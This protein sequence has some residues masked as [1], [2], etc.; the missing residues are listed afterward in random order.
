M[1]AL[2]IVARILDIVNSTIADPNT[3]PGDGGG[4][5]RLVNGEGRGG[6]SLECWRAAADLGFL[7]DN[8]HLK[9]RLVTGC[10]ITVFV[11]ISAFILLLRWGCRKSTELADHPGFNQQSKELT[12]TTYPELQSTSMTV[13]GP[14][15]TDWTVSIPFLST[16]RSTFSNESLNHFPSNLKIGVYSGFTTGVGPRR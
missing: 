7:E 12:A 10:L 16:N 8:H 5:A 4:R 15:P 2:C 11:F 3:V 13:D 6:S 14:G 9:A 1:F